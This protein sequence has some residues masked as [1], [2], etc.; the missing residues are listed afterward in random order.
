[1]YTVW[2]SLGYIW[3][4][5]ESVKHGQLASSGRLVVNLI[6]C[7]H[8]LG[9]SNLWR[10]MQNTLP[11]YMPVC[12]SIRWCV[13]VSQLHFLLL[14]LLLLLG[15][16][17]IKYALNQNQFIVTPATLRVFLI[18]RRIKRKNTIELLT[19]TVKWQNFFE[20]FLLSCSK[21]L[22]HAVSLKYLFL[23]LWL[24]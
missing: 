13:P 1:M 22:N 9:L 5:A 19:W 16:S 2:Q 11:T 23:T 8:T 3:T 7:T 24:Q 10:S 12:F 20:C 4:G 17:K 21:F 15:H 6:S 18:L 14:K